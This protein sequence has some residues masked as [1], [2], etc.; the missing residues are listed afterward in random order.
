MSL[1]QIGETE[2]RGKGLEVMR[3]DEKSPKTRQ[4]Y[5]RPRNVVLKYG[6]PQGEWKSTRPNKKDEGIETYPI[7]PT[8]HEPEQIPHDED[9]RKTNE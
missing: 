9:T 6:N 8:V 7:P 2:E 3:D 1:S 4:W 5:E